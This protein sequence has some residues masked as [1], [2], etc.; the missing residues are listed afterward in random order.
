LLEKRGEALRLRQARDRAWLTF[1]GP[2]HGSGRIKQR[3]EY[4]TALD[5]VR[6]IEEVFRVLGLS[7]CFIYEKYRALYSLDEL[8]VT[9]DEVPMGVYIELEGEPE[10]IEV[11]VEKLGLRMED[12]ISIA[13]P[14]LYQLYRDENP[15]APE[16]MIFSADKR[17]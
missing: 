3:R 8:M 5:D 12:A 16:F 9:L 11:V 2:V 4:E 6:A 7:A 17:P 14:R 13:Y 1:K 15:Q 10:T